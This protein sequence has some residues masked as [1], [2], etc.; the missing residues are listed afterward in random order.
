M[1]SNDQSTPYVTAPRQILRAA[2]NDVAKKIKEIQNSDR[3]RLEAT[4]LCMILAHSRRRIHCKTVWS[5]Q[6]GRGVV[7][8][9]LTDQRKFVEKWIE[10]ERE[11]TWRFPE[12]RW[13][14]AMSGEAEALLDWGDVGYHEWS[15]GAF[16]RKH[17]LC[18]LVAQ[19]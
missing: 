1:N 4:L 7:I 10:A 8:S 6:T 17:N 12:T 2:V 19:P 11:A 9:S 5:K 15:M 13:T 16:V 14:W 18:A 3:D